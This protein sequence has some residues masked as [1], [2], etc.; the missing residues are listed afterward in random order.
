MHEQGSQLA[1]A[2][3]TDAKGG[4]LSATP[5]PAWDQTRPFVEAQ[6]ILEFVP[7]A[8]AAQPGRRRPFPDGASPGF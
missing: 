7:V 8:T 3:F 4:P 6:P 1:A 5:M 2:S